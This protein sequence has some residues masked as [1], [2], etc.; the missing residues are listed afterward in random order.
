MSYK[1]RSFR[2][3]VDKLDLAVTL[4]G[5]EKVLI[6]VNWSEV[7]VIVLG[8]DLEVVLF[9]ETVNDCSRS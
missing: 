5:K 9:D 8:N 3:R 1:Y 6:L 2:V 4:N 7:T